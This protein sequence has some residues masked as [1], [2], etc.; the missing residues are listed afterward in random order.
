MMS[1][2][3][4]LNIPKSPANSAASV[5]TARSKILGI[6]INYN[7]SATKVRQFN[8]IAMTIS[9]CKIRSKYSLTDC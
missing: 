3:S 2:F 4:A 1:I 6:E 7:P 8:H 5:C 9:K